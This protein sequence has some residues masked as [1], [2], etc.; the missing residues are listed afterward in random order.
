MVTSGKTTFEQFG[1][2]KFF[3]T[4]TCI[5]R[6]IAASIRFSHCARDCLSIE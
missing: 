3:A 5:A 1:Q 4:A 6:F 2:G